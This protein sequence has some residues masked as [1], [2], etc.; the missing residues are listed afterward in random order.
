MVGSVVEVVLVL[1]EVELVLVEV[2]LVLVEVELVLVE[3]GLVLVEVELV[4]VEV[5]LVL[6]E[7]ELVEVELE[8]L[9]ELEELVLVDKLLDVVD[10]KAA[11]PA[12]AAGVVV[13]D[14]ETVRL[15]AAACTD[16]VAGPTN[17][18]AAASPL[19]ARRQ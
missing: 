14:L 11:D 16:S 5:G 18:I 1:V 2:G 6:V 8:V 10:R 3:V 13:E 4:L 9:V 19:V 15:L 17:R 12:A 7:V